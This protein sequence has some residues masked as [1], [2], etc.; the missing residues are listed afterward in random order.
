MT[1]YANTLGKKTFTP[2]QIHTFPWEEEFKQKEKIEYKPEDLIQLLEESQRV[3]KM[4]G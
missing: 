3:A 2:Q 4:F 1:F